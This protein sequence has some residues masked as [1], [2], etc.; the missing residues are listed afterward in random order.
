[1]L[2]KAMQAATRK[3]PGATVERLRRA[4]NDHDLDALASC[5]ALEYRNETPLHPSRGFQGRAQVRRNWEQIFAAV[6]DIAAEVTW[7]ADE[8]TVWSEWEMR[9]TRRDGSP[10]LMRGVVIF[11]VEGDEA[12]WARFYLEPVQNGGENADEAVRR[13]VGADSSARQTAIQD[14]QELKR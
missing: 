8:A 14:S 6:P 10:H 1:M 9:G 2:E 3:G 7:I 13:A 11:G 5:F 12:I 4:T